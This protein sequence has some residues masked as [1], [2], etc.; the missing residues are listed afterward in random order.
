M[1]VNIADI[2]TQHAMNYLV[3]DQE[4][5]FN[6]AGQVSHLDT[7]TDPFTDLEINCRS[8]LSLLEAAGTTTPSVKIVFAG[9]GSSTASP[10]TC[11]STRST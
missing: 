2:R 11:R 6:L 4:Y 5:I 3:Q 7:M 9:R 8:Q 10:I 1:R